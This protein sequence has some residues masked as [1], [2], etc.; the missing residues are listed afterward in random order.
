MEFLQIMLRG[1][2]PKNFGA[3]FNFS[4]SVNSNSLREFLFAKVNKVNK[5]ESWE[6]FCEKVKII[7]D[8]LGGCSKIKSVFNNQAITFIIKSSDFDSKSIKEL[9]G[10]RI[11][12]SKPSG[13]V[14][15]PRLVR[16]Q[17]AMCYTPW[18]LDDNDCLKRI[19]EHLG[20]SFVW[21][22]VIKDKFFRL[23]TGRILVCVRVEEI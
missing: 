2:G 20:E 17:R 8:N 15:W 11:K 5:T 14:I 1:D 7:I 19:E 4:G 6:G 22:R 18:W 12:V 13:E 16:K 21:G 9:E 10:T 23:P 3:R